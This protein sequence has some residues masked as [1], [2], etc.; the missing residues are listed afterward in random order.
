[1]RHLDFLRFSSGLLYIPRVLHCFLIN[2]GLCRRPVF[3][4]TEDMTKGSTPSI[5]MVNDLSW[6][7]NHLIELF[8]FSVF[9]FIRDVLILLWS[10]CHKLIG[11]FHYLLVK[12]DHLSFTEWL[13]VADMRH[14]GLNLIH[15]FGIA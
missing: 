8:D 5:V 4:N 11:T 6:H 9:D 13:K 12:R 2:N 3:L 10:L 15:E 1:M 7:L 14:Q